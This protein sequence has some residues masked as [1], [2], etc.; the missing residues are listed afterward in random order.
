MNIVLEIGN[1]AVIVRAK[2]GDV[3]LGFIAR[4]VDVT[5]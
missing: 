1:L 3:R 4:D 2:K 5:T